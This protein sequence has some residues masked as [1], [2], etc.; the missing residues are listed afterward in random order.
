LSLRFLLD[1]H[2]VVRWLTAPKKLSR[3]QTQVLR[4][5][6]LN[7][8]PLGVSAITLLEIALL[9]GNGAARSDLRAADLLGDLESNPAIEIVPFTL[10]VAAEVAALG[11][12]L[13]DYRDRAIVATARV[14]ALR[15]LTSDQRII[16]SNL[17]PVVA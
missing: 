17:V 14:R 1:T 2:I 16:D 5:A 15:L 9:F 10:D 7:R 11:T 12:S 13:S 8:E 3:E 4:D 6:V